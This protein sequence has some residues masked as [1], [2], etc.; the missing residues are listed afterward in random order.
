MY[1]LFWVKLSENFFKKINLPVTE[2]AANK[3]PITELVTDKHDE[4]L[5]IFIYIILFSHDK[6]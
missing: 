1:Q 4:F 3:T 5:D 6:L 2:A